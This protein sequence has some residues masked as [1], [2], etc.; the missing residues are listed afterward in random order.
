MIT[1]YYDNLIDQATLTASSENALF[2]VKNIKDPRRTKVFRSNSNQ[3]SV[4]FDFMETSQFDSFLIT[5]NWVHGFGI[6]TILIEANGTDEWSSPP[7]STTMTFST[8][9]HIGIKELEEVQSY[10]FVRMTFNST[11]DYCELAN[12]FIGMKMKPSRGLNR[13]WTFK[14]DDL[15]TVKEN[16]YTQKFVDINGRQRIFAGQINNLDNA[17]IEKIRDI[18]DIKGKVKP[19]FVKIGCAETMGDIDRYTAMVYFSSIPSNTNRFYQNWGLPINL[20]E[21]K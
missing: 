20:E 6:S 1:F 11:L 18:T 10:R 16:R 2:P 8:K 9:H 7:F 21:A 15:S 12:L 3:T 17:N 5:D 4:V 14:D 13:S 19:L